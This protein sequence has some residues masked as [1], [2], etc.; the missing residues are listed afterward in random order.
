MKRIYTVVAVMGVVMVSFAVASSL[1]AQPGNPDVERVKAKLLLM[2]KQI[3]ELRDRG[4]VDEARVLAEQAEALQ[5][6]TFKGTREGTGRRPLPGQESKEQAQ[7]RHKLEFLRSNGRHEQ[8]EIL[9]RKFDEHAKRQKQSTGERGQS[10]EDRIR[11]LLGNGRV[12]EAKRLTRELREHLEREHGER[13][14]G[15]ADDNHNHG[16]HRHDDHDHHSHGEE[17]P[18]RER[19]LQGEQ[20]RPHDRHERIQHLQ[21]AAEHLHAAGLHEDGERIMQAAERLAHELPAAAHVERLG[22]EMRAIGEHVRQVTERLQ[23][24]ESIVEKIVNH[25]DRDE[26]EQRDKD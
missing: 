25:I 20:E 4:A 3:A 26:D 23:R 18:A 8:A 14:H 9:E 16:A 7:L 5:A 1:R 15:N 24:L 11:G 19:P 13:A 10:L 17:R 21:E 6:E 2:R 22:Q 12:E